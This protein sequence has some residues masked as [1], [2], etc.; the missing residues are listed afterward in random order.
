[1]TADDLDGFKTFESR[2][3]FMKSVRRDAGLLAAS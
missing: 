2:D 1:M 3:R